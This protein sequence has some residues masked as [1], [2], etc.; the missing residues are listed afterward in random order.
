[1]RAEVALRSLT[2]H[3]HLLPG[4]PDKLVKQ[5][6]SLFFLHTNFL[7]ECSPTVIRAPLA[8]WAGRQTMDEVSA[9][10]NYTSGRFSEAFIDGDHYDL[11]YPPFVNSIATQL[12]TALTQPRSRRAVEETVLV[13][14]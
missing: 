9:W 7:G 4:L 12:T 3:G 10:R 2:A 5:Y 13:P 11:M 1:M 8:V 6:L 14:A